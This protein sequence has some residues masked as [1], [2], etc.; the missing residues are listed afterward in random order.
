MEMTLNPICGFKYQRQ[1][2]HA[3]IAHTWRIHQD[4]ILSLLHSEMKPLILVGAA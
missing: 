1:Y 2:L 3:S 4:E